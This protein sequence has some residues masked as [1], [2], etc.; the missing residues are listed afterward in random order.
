MAALRLEVVGSHKATQ[1]ELTVAVEGGI[2]LKPE[3]TTVLS[4]HHC[5]CFCSGSLTLSGQ[6]LHALLQACG[7]WW[8]ATSSSS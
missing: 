4:L 2:E 7:K 3:L 6:G 1:K 8:Q 5:P